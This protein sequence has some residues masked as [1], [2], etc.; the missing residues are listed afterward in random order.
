MIL[1]LKKFIERLKHEGELHIVETQVDSRLEI[2][3]IADRMIKQ[4][5]PA[6]LFTNVKDSPFPVAINLFGSPRRMNLAL[7]VD[8]LD[9]VS[10][11]IA[12][13]LEMK[14]P[15]TFGE[16]VKM[17]P[18]LALLAKTA[19]KVVKNAPCQEVIE[20][21]PKLSELPVIQC[22][23]ED[24]GRY[25]TLPMVITK[26]PET[27]VRNVGCYRMQVY[28]D[29]STGM[30]WQVHKDGTTHY[31]KAKELGL[32]RLEVAVA[33]G[34]DPI[35]MFSA[36]CPLP[37]GIDEFA[38]AGFLR[39]K[40]VELVKCRTVDL[41]VPADSEFV[42]E[43]Y[44][45]LKEMRMEGPFGDHTGYYSAAKE[46]PVFHVTT[47]TRR[48]DPIYATTIVGKPPMEDGYMG[49]A[50][51]RIFLPLLKT[52]LPEI[53]DMSLPMQGAFHNCIL[54]SIKKAYPHHARKI[55]NSV[56]GM[57]QLI[58]E[59][60][61]L[62]FDHDVDLNDANEVAWRA[63]ANI[64]PKR[65]MVFSEG[66][67]DELDISAS[68][69]LYGSKLGVDCTRKWREEGME[70]D[71]PP[72]IIMDEHTRDLVTKRWKE[73]GLEDYSGQ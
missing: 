68:R 39:E 55:M 6:L 8:S 52:Q 25:I 59:K 2:T 10:A 60:M 4:Q 58:F 42:L 13:M 67:I 7:D 57:G 48:K 23:P 70:R 5:G 22:W 12:K 1:S 27:G 26:D 32:E 34:A 36:V 11:K 69:E 15:Q 37:F 41:E 16:K 17:L 14:V 66:P 64:D 9:Q 61:V 44:V 43:G 20:T 62:V 33:L 28:D 18:R 40:P 53:V 29:Q 51:E 50:I 45:D 21:N 46:F 19:P 38:L 47:L 71:W 3:E 73:Y 24:A 56:W 65:D 72:D 35:T 30:H 31:R 54:V 49:K 63:T